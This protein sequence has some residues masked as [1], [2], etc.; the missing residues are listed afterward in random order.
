MDEEMIVY[1]GHYS[2]IMYMRGKPIK[3]GYKLWVLAT[4]EGYPLNLQVYVEKIKIH[5]KGKMQ[6]KLS[7]L[8]QEV[9]LT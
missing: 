5:L 7:P 4:A 3:S 8:E 1:T 6:Q 2:E 9:F